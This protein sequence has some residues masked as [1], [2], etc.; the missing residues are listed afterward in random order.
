VTIEDTPITPAR[1]DQDGFYAFTRVPEGTYGATAGGTGCSVPETGELV[2]S[3]PT[4]LDFTLPARRDG[5]GY[6]CGL[7][8][9]AFEEAETILPITGDDVAGTVDLPFPFTFYGQTYTRAHVCTNG[10]VEFAGPVATSCPGGNAAIPTTGRPNGEI[11][12]FWDDTFVDAE[13]SI[14]ADVRGTA[15]DRRLV[16]EYRNLHF[17]NDTARRVDFNVVLFENGEILTQYRNIANDGRERGNSATLGIESHTG[18]DALR[19]ALN[20]EVLDT[21]P[22][23]TSIRYRPPPP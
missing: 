12:S 4:T 15:P 21:Q 5:F 3:G 9:A 2:V 20:Q 13:A 19:F 8:T 18:T 16:I 11:A 14:R 6:T 7:E 1:T 17:F 22:A 10:F 23:V